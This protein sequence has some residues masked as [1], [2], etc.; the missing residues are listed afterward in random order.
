M[1]EIEPQRPRDKARNDA[2]KDEKSSEIDLQRLRKEVQK[3][4]RNDAETDE[5][6]AEIQPQGPRDEVRNDAGKG[7]KASEIDRQRPRKE[8][9]NEAEILPK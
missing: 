1:A 7:Q 8:V 5:E 2:R 4:G 6:M 3:G 9:Q